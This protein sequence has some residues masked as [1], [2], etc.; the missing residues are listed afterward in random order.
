MMDAFGAPGDEPVISEP[1]LSPLAPPSQRKPATPPPAAD[2]AEPG[3]REPFFSPP[4][5]LG[6]GPIPSHDPPPADLMEQV[7]DELGS[8]FPAAGQS[9]RRGQAARP[10]WLARVLKQFPQLEPLQRGRPIFFLPVVGGLAAL[11]AL[12][13]FG[14]LVRGCIAI[15]SPSE[16][17]RADKTSVQ[18]ADSSSR[19]RAIAKAGSGT[20]PPPSPAAAE[21]A[22]AATTASPAS[23]SASI[24]CRATGTQKSLA[25][26]AVVGSG[27]EAIAFAKTIGIG[28]ATSPKDGIALEVDP[29]TLNVTS[30]ARAHGADLKRVTPLQTGGH[31]VAIGDSDRRGAI[32]SGRVVAG[33][34]GTSSFVIGA[35]DG[36]L[37]LVQHG[38]AI[39]NLWPLLGDASA[40]VEAVRGASDGGGWSVAFRRGAAIYFGSIGNQMKPLGG[41]VET[42]GFGTQVGS[43]SVATSAGITLAMWAD[44]SSPDQPWA[45]RMRRARGSQAPEEARAF[46]PSGGPGAP[47]IAPSVVGLEAGRFLVVWTEGPAQSHQVR[48]ATLN[49][50]GQIDGAPFALS[51]PTVNAGQAQVALDPEGRGVVA[52]LVGNG[53]GFEVAGAGVTCTNR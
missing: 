4:T 38:T 10:E 31:L 52:Y 46:T 7:R 48:G 47:F 12:I 22:A 23:E 28:F 49:A 2:V 21:T 45:L 42:P 26:K 11:V 16:D 15:I 35:R 33:S 40:P 20:L 41:L 43:P 19:A 44:R 50:E 25:P 34:G 37:A 5:L 36:Q 3:S 8:D 18:D 30:T 24:T 14:L 9:G 29:T 53:H 1:L 32:T 27:V 13:T 51:P 6:V 39:T 17:K